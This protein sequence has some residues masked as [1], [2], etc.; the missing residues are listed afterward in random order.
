MNMKGVMA[1]TG[2]ARHQGSNVCQEGMTGQEHVIKTESIRYT[3]KRDLS[4]T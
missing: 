1:H 4:T 2:G 3:F